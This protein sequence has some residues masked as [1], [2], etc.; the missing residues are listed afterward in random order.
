MHP[1]RGYLLR[2]EGLTKDFG[3]LR[4]VDGLDLTLEPGEL[5]GFLGPNGAGKTT[6]IKMMVGLLRPTSGRV[7]ICGHDIWE[8]PVEAKARFGYVPDEPV[9]YSKLTGRQML[10]LVADL[11]RMPPAKAAERISDLLDSFDLT[12]QADDP[13]AAYSHGMR[14]KTA[15]AAALLPGPEVLLLDE[16]TVGLDPKTAR[17]TKDALREFCRRGGA[18]FMST[19]ILEIAE[20]MCTRVGI[21]DHGRLVAAGTVEELRARADRIE[22]SLEDIFLRLTGGEEAAEAANL[23]GIGAGDGLV[24]GLGGGPSGGS[25]RGPGTGGA[26]GDRAPDAED[27]R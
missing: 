7:W 8:E 5:F 3:R 22:G 6:T 17:L 14:Q 23:L 9:L 15:L 16:P 10:T 18:V 26:R 11:Y 1:G 12:G 25:D 13:I 21:I 20:I 4:A 19:H 2:A 27:Q 24:G